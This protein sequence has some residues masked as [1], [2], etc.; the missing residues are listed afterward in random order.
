MCPRFSEPAATEAMT[1][2]HSPAAGDTRNLDDRPHVF[3]AMLT[4]SV[5]CNVDA[6]IWTPEAGVAAAALVAQC[7]LRSTNKVS[8]SACGPHNVASC[9]NI[10]ALRMLLADLSNV[11]DK[12][13]TVG[14][15]LRY[16][17]VAPRQ[18]RNH[19]AAHPCH[20][21]HIVHR[22]GRFTRLWVHVSG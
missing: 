5:L 22:I 18:H 15:D 8:V 9:C 3:A 10:S 12:T 21:V 19:T 13:C 11:T 7:L 16:L 17:Q 6:L 14:S 1:G 2:G 20:V 4:V